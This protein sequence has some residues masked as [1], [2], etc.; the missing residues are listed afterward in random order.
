M[1]REKRKPHPLTGR[2]QSPEQIAKRQATMA[3][4]RVARNQPVDAGRVHDAIYYLRRAQ[5]VA[6]K[7][8]KRDPAHVLAE[9]ALLTLQGDL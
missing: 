1:S 3:A 4:K 2:K 8:E 7:S 6:A 5:K 9:L